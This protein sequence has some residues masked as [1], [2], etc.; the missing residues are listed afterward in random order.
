M[1]KLF[2]SLCI[3]LCASFTLSAQI[4]F[5]DDFESYGVGDY[6]GSNSSDWTTWSGTV[7]T[8]EDVIVTDQQSAS[9]SHSI[10]FSS[11][12]ANGGPQD[13][14]LPFGDKYT[15]GTFEF[16]LNVYVDADAGAYWNFQGET[17]IGQVWALNVTMAEDGNFFVTN[18]DNEL[19]LSSTYAHETWVNIAFEINLTANSWKVLL[20]GECIGAFTNVTNAIASLDLFPLNGNSFYVDDISFSHTENALSLDYDA[21]VSLD[22]LG[23]GG[24]TGMEREITGTISNKG[25]EIITDVEVMISSP[26]GSENFTID[27]LDLANGEFTSFALPNN[28]I[29]VEGTQNIIVE[30]LSI[31]NGQTDAEPCNDRNSFN[32]LGVTPADGKS[33]VVE[34]GTGTWCGWCPRG[35]VFLE[36]LTDKYGDRFIGI[37]VH[38]GDPMTVE[39]YD[40]NIGFSAWPSATVM[41]ASEDTG[42]GSQADLEGPF[43]QYIAEAPKGT[44]SMN[45]DFD[46][47]SRMLNLEVGVFANEELNSGNKLVMVIKEDNVTGTSTDYAQANF[48]AGADID[49]DGYENA[50]NPVPAADM[51]Y[52]HVA[53]AIPLGFGGED[54]FAEAIAAGDSRIYNYELEISEDFDAEKIYIVMMILN[55]DGTIDNAHKAQMSGLTSNINEVV[56]TNDISVFPNPASELLNIEMTILKADE[57]QLDITDVTGKVLQSTELD[58]AVGKTTYTVDINALPSGMYYAVL[59]NGDTSEALKFVKQ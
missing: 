6:I 53:R 45:G 31:N 52:D 36:R 18:S 59:K 7:G 54:S 10:Y 15:S 11:T 2:Y 8:N 1:K 41:R 46:T 23:I 57:L 5:S 34:E 56:A 44:F 50:P 16:G 14:V 42:F 12:G 30:L 20:D 26:A 25:T 40:D 28:Y 4:S 43:L 48:Y 3:V 58:A 32:L 17:T 47:D 22:D 24:L 13:V 49:M 55:E 9:G 39:E 38:N 27:N 19:V 35:A 51:V 33:V 29:L 21:S 37:A